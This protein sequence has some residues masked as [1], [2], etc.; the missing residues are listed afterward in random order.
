MR[1]TVWELG[2]L[3]EATYINGHV[4]RF[5]IHQAQSPRFLERDHC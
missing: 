2:R 1:F 4:V 5:R 3:P